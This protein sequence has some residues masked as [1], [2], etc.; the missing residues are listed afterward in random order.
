MRDIPQFQF[1]DSCKTDKQKFAYISGKI[2]KEFKL[3]MEGNLTVTTHK[4]R[5]GEY[6]IGLKKSVKK[7]KKKWLK[8]LR[9]WFPY[10]D[11]QLIQRCMRMAK[12]IDID[13]FP[14]IG[15]LPQSHILDMIQHGKNQTVDQFLSDHGVDPEPKITDAKSIGMFRSEV[16]NMM[17]KVIKHPGFTF[18]E[19]EY[20]KSRSDKWARRQQRIDELKWLRRKEKLAKKKAKARGEKV[21]EDVSVARISR[22]TRTL[23]QGLRQCVKMGDIEHARVEMAMDLMDFKELEE[24]S[25]LLDQIFDDFDWIDAMHLTPA[26]IDL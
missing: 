24:L 17:V 7:N 12:R 1:P 6:F 9:K 18:V 15:H 3:I 26:E 20:D 16:N 8:A 23:T 10:I 11:K 21:D 19:D 22:A 2:E 4:I 5:M 14:A 25:G 13:A